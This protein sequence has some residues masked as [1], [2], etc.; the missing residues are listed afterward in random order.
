MVDVP[1][2]EHEWTPGPGDILPA[3]GPSVDELRHAAY[4]APGGADSIYMKWQR[5][6]ATEQ[7]WLDAV[8]AV[9]ALYPDPEDPVPG[10]PVEDPEPEP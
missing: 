4:T 2:Q 1:M 5:G 3:L 10:M 9:K 6:D 8:A 7:E